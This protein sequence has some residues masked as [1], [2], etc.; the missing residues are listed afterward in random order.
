MRNKVTMVACEK[1][2][3]ITGLNVSGLRLNCC[4][5]EYGYADMKGSK[6]VAWRS[7]NECERLEPFHPPPR[8]SDETTPYAEGAADT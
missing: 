6:T 1:Q 7:R 3:N 8:V 4:F 5:H 2:A